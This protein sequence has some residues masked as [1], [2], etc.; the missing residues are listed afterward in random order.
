MVLADGM[1]GDA[2][3]ASRLAITTLTHL[4]LSFGRWNL[5]I[6]EAI[7]DEVMDRAERFFRNIDL[8]LS[9]A[10]GTAHSDCRRRSRLS[11]TLA[12]SCSSLT[13]DIRAP[14][15]FAMAN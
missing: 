10:G 4:T 1:G 3:V 7:A 6:N 13:W 5:R 12:R 15:C 14:I 9:Q 2:E 8:A 11:S